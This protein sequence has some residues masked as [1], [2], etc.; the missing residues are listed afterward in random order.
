MV[1]VRVKKL[2]GREYAYKVQNTWTSK[3]PRQT[4]KEYL[5]RVYEHKRTKS[6]EFTDIFK[7]YTP[8]LMAKSEIIRDLVTVE[9]YN[10]GFIKTQ[11]SH[12]WQKGESV[13][14][15]RSLTFTNTK[16][17]PAVLR[18]NEGFLCGSTVQQ[19]LETK[20]ENEV[21]GRE[22]FNLAKNIVNAGLT[23]PKDLFIALYQRFRSS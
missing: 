10:H 6:E 13:V 11:K 12:I 22:G 8:E 2:K 19:I 3:G 17:K 5:G 18:M 21:E 4:S 9:L 20:S 7:E 16:R 1:F 15:T 14:N 23:I